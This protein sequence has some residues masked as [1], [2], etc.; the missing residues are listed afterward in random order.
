MAFGLMMGIV[1]VYFLLILARFEKLNMNFLRISILNIRSGL[2]LPALSL[3]A[4]VSI[5]SPSLYIIMD[6]PISLVE[7]YSLLSFFAVMVEFAGGHEEFLKLIINSIEEEKVSTS[8]RISSGKRIAGSRYS[9][10]CRAIRMQFLLRPALILVNSMCLLFGGDIGAS[11]GIVF[12]I[13]SSLI[14]FRG[15]YLLSSLYFTIQPQISIMRGWLR[16]C[17]MFAIILGHFS[18]RTTIYWGIKL[19]AFSVM[20]NSAH[21]KEIRLVVLMLSISL[22]IAIPYF[23]LYCRLPNQRLLRPCSLNRSTQLSAFAPSQASKNCAKSAV[24]PVGEDVDDIDL[25]SAWKVVV[26]P[27]LLDQRIINVHPDA[28]HDFDFEA[29]SPLKPPK[30]PSV[31]PPL[32]LPSTE[33]DFLSKYSTNKLKPGMGIM[34]VR[35][36]RKLHFYCFLEKLFLLHDTF[37]I[38]THQNR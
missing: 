7:A 34:A 6:L 5:N 25:E 35:A 22:I 30:I 33:N 11:V 8:K 1:A 14:L 38:L 26:K 18:C 24:F 36:D 20:D 23:M 32:K 13:L 3:L 17:A 27:K 16:Q 37:S 4:F 12:H 9:A 29:A 21:R 31:V 10:V 2:Y 15:M 28:V 19:N